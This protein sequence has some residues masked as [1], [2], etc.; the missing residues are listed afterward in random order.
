MIKHIF[1]A[2]LTV[3]FIK[4]PGF[5]AKPLE[6]G[7]LV[8]DA[9]IESILKKLTNPLFRVAGLN[10]DLSKLYIVIDSDINAAAT[11]G[12]RIFINSGLIVQALSVGQ[13]AGVLAHETGHIAS[14]HIL[15]RLDAMD[16]ASILRMAGYALGA[17]VAAISGRTEG[18]VAAAMG[19]EQAAMGAIL[20]YS[21]GQESAADQAAVRYL[22][23][24]GWP[25]EDFYTMMKTL[26]KQELLSQTHQEPYMRTHPL[27]QERVSFLE[28]CMHSQ[29]PV[30]LGLS[31]D[32]EKDFSLAQ[33]KLKAYTQSPGQTLLE[34]SEKN[35]DV[36][37][38][39]ARAIAFYRDHR[40]VDALKTLMRVKALAPNN[41]FL[42]EFE[43]M[44][45]FEEA[46]LDKARDAYRKAY[47]MAPHEPL[48]QIAYAQTLLESNHS[49]DVLEARMLL[50][51]AILKEEDYPQA[52]HFL[53][54]SYGKTKD[55]ALASYALAQEALCLE[56]YDAALQQIERAL[57]GRVP[58]NIRQKLNDMKG[59]LQ[60]LKSQQREGLFG[61][62]SQH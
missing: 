45:Y 34:F 2:F 62:L 53:A 6:K 39:Y 41:A 21:R 46:R 14:G 18:F 28:H 59:V 15:R 9:E 42:W 8:R 10:P 43:G 24:L 60:D 13:V 50:E 61:D 37:S 54:V 22:T 51:K 26:L 35:Q 20:K 32:L 57:K 40:I 49:K 58:N 55:P 48:I 3:F 38:L 36:A 12:Y 16:K 29:I 17:A 23:K 5:A 11:I 4:N 47:Q 31:H 27:S 33:A 7:I 30:S 56:K 19:G 1:F 52:W 44:L 25:V